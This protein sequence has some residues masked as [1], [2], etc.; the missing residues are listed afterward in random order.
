MTDQEKKSRTLQ[1]W[2][3]TILIGRNPRWTLIRIVILVVVCTVVFKFILL[4]IRVRGS[5]MSPTYRDGGVNFVILL[6]YSR[7]EPQRF[8]VVSIRTSGISYMYLKRIIGLP[9]ETI[10]FT[11]GKLFVN[12]KF[13]E[14]PF[15]KS[16]N[17]LEMPPRTLGP[18]E[19]FVAGDNRGMSQDGVATRERIVGKVLL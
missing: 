9:G 11:D 6:S 10:E 1:W 4:P 12:G 17:H 8:D 19:Y 5:S 13:V 3:Q 14:E 18:D 2:M 7:H 15:L 16:Q